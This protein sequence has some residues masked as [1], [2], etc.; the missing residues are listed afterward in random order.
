MKKYIKHKRKKALRS[1]HKLERQLKSEYGYDRFL[2]YLEQKE[3]K[4]ANNNR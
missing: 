2:E 3:K 4:V 1:K